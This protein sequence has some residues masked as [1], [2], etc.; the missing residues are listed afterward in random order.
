MG[1]KRIALFF[2]IS[3][4]FALF[5]FSE[6][7]PSFEKEDSSELANHM[8]ELLTT[9]RELQEMNRELKVN[10]DEKEKEA[11]NARRLQSEYQWDR[12]NQGEYFRN[13]DHV[14]YESIGRELK[15]RLW[16]LYYISSH[17]MMGSTKHLEDQLLSLL[18][19]SSKLSLMDGAAERRRISLQAVTDSI[20]MKLN[21]T[22]WKHDCSK[23]KFL[24]CTVID[25]CG[26]ACQV[27]HLAYCL[28]V[29]F[30]YNRVVVLRNEGRPWG[31]HRH[32]WFGPFQPFSKC[33]APAEARWNSEIETILG[34]NR[35]LLVLNSIENPNRPDPFPPSIPKTIAPQLIQLHSNPPAFFMGQF[36]WFILKPKPQIYNFVEM[37]ASRI[38]FDSGLIVGV[39]VRR[40]DKLD[41]E[42]KYYPVSEYMKWCELYFQIEERRI[43]RALKRRVYVASDEPSVL[44]EVKV[45]YPNYE[46]FGDA[47]FSKGAKINSRYSER[48]LRGL[49]TDLLLLS[50]CNYLVCTFSS[51]F[52]RLAYE[53]MQVRRGD[54]GESYRSLDDMYYFGGQQP[55]EHIVIED[56]SPE[57]P[58]EISL[59]IGDI[60]T[61]KSN[62]WNGYFRG[63]N[64]KT[65]EE[66]LYPSYKVEEK[67]KV[68]DF[69]ALEDQIR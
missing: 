33:G 49:L 32:G 12:S 14:I 27:H 58:D 4:I 22:Q 57:N 62:L 52:C 46:V 38:P 1:A 37:S 68:V 42:M 10:L 41:R 8:T 20:Q 40:T 44:D 63:R 48:S 15:R 51:H 24:G 19:T 66:G 53:L 17:P 64:S 21:E 47:A 59:K 45:K 13:H 39:H 5:Y 61:V 31:Y 6:R 69:P 36:A 26:F 30:A 9:I 11:E 3:W 65:E 50:R 35:T 16:E 2:A 67:W 23:A 28:F 60:L 56:H 55:H 18:V 43:K 54:V 34:D 7:T 29:A 25:T